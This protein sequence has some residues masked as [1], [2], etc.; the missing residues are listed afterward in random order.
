MGRVQRAPALQYDI[1]ETTGFFLFIAV[2]RVA[3]SGP[4]RYSALCTVLSVVQRNMEP[5]QASM[6]YKATAPTIQCSAAQF[7]PS[8][9]RQRH[10]L[11]THTS[12]KTTYKSQHALLHCSHRSRWHRLCQPGVQP[13]PPIP[14][15]R[16]VYLNCWS[17][18]SGHPECLCDHL[19][20]QP[21]A[22]LPQ[23]CFVY[24]YCWL[25]DSGHSRCWDYLRLQP[26]A[27]LP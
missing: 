22:L 17:P 24:F 6:F 27:L 25:S 15:G 18:F 11:P 8:F 13:S 5:H 7:D 16:S 14:G 20:L 1:L 26:G 23:W 9:E 4:W 2:C 12:T 19:C 10:S 3:Y 21:G